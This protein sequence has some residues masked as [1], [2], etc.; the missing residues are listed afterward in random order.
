MHLLKAKVSADFL[1]AVKTGV[2]RQNSIG[3]MYEEDWTPGEF[4]VEKY[5]FF[6]AQD[7]G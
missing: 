5:D 7:F 2:L 4:K 3:F 6:S 1:A